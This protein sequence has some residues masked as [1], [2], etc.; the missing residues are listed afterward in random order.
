MAGLVEGRRTSRA[1]EA[2]SSTSALPEP[3]VIAQPMAE[4]E[5]AVPEQE[6]M[7]GEAHGPPA[8]ASGQPPVSDPVPA[9]PTPP[10]T[11]EHPTEAEFCLLY[12]V[13][14]STLVLV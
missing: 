2:P 9:P 10:V 4:G 8:V 6:P 12:N 11:P 7:N 14:S 5:P 13:L 1:Q 3:V